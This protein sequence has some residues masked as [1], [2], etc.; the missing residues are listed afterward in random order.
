MDFFSP[1]LSQTNKPRDRVFLG[2]LEK[3]VEYSLTRWLKSN[4]NIFAIFKVQ[5]LMNMFDMNTLQGGGNA[6]SSEPAETEGSGLLHWGSILV[7]FHHKPH[8]WLYVEFSSLKVLLNY[9]PEIREPIR[10]FLVSLRDWPVSKQ[11]FALMLHWSLLFVGANGLQLTAAHL[12]QE[13]SWRA[14]RTP[15]TVLENSGRVGRM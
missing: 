4:V 3:A 6:T 15:P 9:L 5:A 11:W 10:K 7:K 13:E 14:A 2:D 12:V 8:Y 1:H